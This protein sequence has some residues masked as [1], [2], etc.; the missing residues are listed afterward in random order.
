MKNETYKQCRFQRKVNG[1][2]ANTIA[3]IPSWAAKVGNEVQL[4]TLDAEFWMVLEVGQEIDKE[5]M[6]AL[7]RGHKDF[8]ESLKGGGIDE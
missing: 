4:L 2:V 8:Q 3:Y 6:K 5:T 1:A 7:G